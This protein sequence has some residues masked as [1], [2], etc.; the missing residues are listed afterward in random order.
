MDLGLLDRSFGYRS[1]RG[2]YT[3]GQSHDA[4]RRA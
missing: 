4:S 3:N 2:K 1:K